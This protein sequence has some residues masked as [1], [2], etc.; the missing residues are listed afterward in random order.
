[1]PDDNGLQL[2]LYLGVVRERSGAL[3]EAHLCLVSN[4]NQDQLR[5]VRVQLIASPSLSTNWIESLRVHVSIHIYRAMS[6]APLT[7]C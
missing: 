2:H 6:I 4:Q 5:T 1:M 3:Q 7:E